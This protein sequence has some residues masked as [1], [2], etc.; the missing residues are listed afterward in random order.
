M[1]EIDRLPVGMLERIVEDRSIVRAIGIYKQNP[2]ATGDVI[3]LVRLV[4]FEEVQ[5]ELDVQQLHH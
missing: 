2:K 5:A 4:E 3:D 1:A